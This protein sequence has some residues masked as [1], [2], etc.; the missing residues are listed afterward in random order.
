[1]PSQ[2]PNKTP[3]SQFR[4]DGIFRHRYFVFLTALIDAPPLPSGVY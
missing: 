2:Y 3:S 4:P 1:L